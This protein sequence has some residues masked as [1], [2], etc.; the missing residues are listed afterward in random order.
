MHQFN[1]IA[2]ESIRT[3]IICVT[4]RILAHVRVIR[5]RTICAEQ[6]QS[7]A[8]EKMYFQKTEG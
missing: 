5:R 1:F 6:R 2:A 8:L 7:E 3:E 4:G